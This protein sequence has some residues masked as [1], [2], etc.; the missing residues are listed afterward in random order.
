MSWEN[1]VD[2]VLNV[3]VFA[4]IGGLVWLYLKP[5]PREGE[6]HGDSTKPGRTN[7]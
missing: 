2:T 4:F 7:E 6:S 5:E 1:L 3:V